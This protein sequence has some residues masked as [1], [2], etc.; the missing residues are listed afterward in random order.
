M[1]L[2]RLVS[3]IALAICI[4]TNVVSAQDLLALYEGDKANG[5][6]PS[7]ILDSSGK[8]NHAVFLG[9]AGLVDAGVNGGALNFNADTS[10]AL[11]NTPASG[12]FDSISDN[13][14][15]T[16]GYWAYGGDSNPRNSST[17]WA[18]GVEGATDRAIQAHGTWG[19]SQIYLDIG[20]CCS[21]T[22]RLNGVLEDQFIRGSETDEW[23]HFAF[24]LDSEFGDARIYVNGEIY[25]NGDFFAERF[26]PTDEVP[27]ISR[28][29]I[30]SGINGGNQWE[31]RMDDFFVADEAL[32]EDDIAKVYNEGIRS[33]FTDLPAEPEEY[34]PSGGV[35]LRLENVDGQLG[36]AAFVSEG[37]GEISAWR[38]EE[39]FT[40]TAG[41]QEISVSANLASAGV[42]GTEAIGDGATSA[43]LGDVPLVNLGADDLTRTFR[44]LADVTGADDPVLGSDFSASMVAQIT[45]PGSGGGGEIPELVLKGDLDQDG[46]IGFDD[47]LILSANFGTSGE[48]ALGVPEPCSGI[49]ALVGTLALLG[50][51]RRRKK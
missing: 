12:G 36:G 17:F 15:F 50:V 29:F 37:D 4:A 18:E 16:I 7:I 48:A 6:N 47:F 39:I 19:N 28:M 34:T 14:G 30:A 3:A 21:G 27:F 38:V 45:L 31:G 26:G 40:T 43:L 51:R 13:Q 41:G 33:V 46:L 10:Y 2:A 23:T 42:A 22:Q 25:E 8:G 11:V 24:T 9:S 20:G 35:E 44:I 49:T 5:P 32:S 1:N